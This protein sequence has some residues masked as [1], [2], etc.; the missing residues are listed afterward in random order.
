MFKTSQATTVFR[1]TMGDEKHSWQENEQYWWKRKRKQHLT[2][3]EYHL[4]TLFPEKV[5]DSVTKEFLPEN[6][7]MLQMDY[8]KI[9]KNTMHAKAGLIDL[10]KLG[11]TFIYY[12]QKLH[13]LVQ[14]T[15]NYNVIE[16]NTPIILIINWR[17]IEKFGIH[18][19]AEIT[20]EK[21]RSIDNL[22]KDCPR[23]KYNR[24]NCDCIRPR[25]KYM[26]YRS[27]NYGREHRNKKS[28]N[29]HTMI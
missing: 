13:V 16:N 11:T 12:D 19:E 8:I 20:S 3:E 28:Y 18:A 9:T 26:N 7:L 22:W 2:Q 25:D 17:N 6:C 5:L 1:N 21:R 15:I 27:C 4:Y 10:P 24:H 23:T 29:N 14:A